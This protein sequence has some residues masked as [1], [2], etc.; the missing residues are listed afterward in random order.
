MDKINFGALSGLFLRDVP[1]IYLEKLMRNKDFQE[2]E[3]E[4][5][6]VVKNYIS[7]ELWKRKLPKD[8]G[9]GQD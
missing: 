9:T 8:C 6:Q 7:K 1:I 4:D 5:A 3:D 2:R